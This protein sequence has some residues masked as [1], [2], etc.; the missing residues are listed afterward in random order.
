MSINTNIWRYITIITIIVNNTIPTHGYSIWMTMRILTLRKGILIKYKMNMDENHW[1][2]TPLVV[3]TL[4]RRMQKRVVDGRG[5]GERKTP[6]QE[7]RALKKNLFE[8]KNPIE[9]TISWIYYRL[10]HMLSVIF[11]LSLLCSQ[12]LLRLAYWSW[13][14]PGRLVDKSLGLGLTFPL[15]SINS[16]CEFRVACCE[17]RCALFAFRGL[18]RF[19]RRVAC[20]TRLSSDTS[21]PEYKTR[22]LLTLVE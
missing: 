12:E 14:E 7:R 11:M 5:V 8:K 9:G 3:N 10:Y 6:I 16:V 1:I 21:P 19:T 13:S 17:E 22:L 15:L 4:G 18:A 2:T 20:S